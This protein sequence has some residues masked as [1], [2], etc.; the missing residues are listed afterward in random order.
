[1]KIKTKKQKHFTTV[2][3]I[4]ESEIEKKALENLFDY[5]N[6]MCNAVKKHGKESEEVVNEMR[7]LYDKIG[8]AVKNS[9]M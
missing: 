4:V 5:T 6:T 1:M 9:D 7:A 2:T 3:I 8:E